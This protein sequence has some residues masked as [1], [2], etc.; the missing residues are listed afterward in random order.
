MAKIVLS[1]GSN[2]EPRINH[3][4]QAVKTISG[5]AIKGTMASSLFYETEP[6]GFISR[7]EFINMAISFNAD[8]SPS[9]LLEKIN[10]LEQSHGRI[11]NKGITEDRTIDID[12]LFYDDLILADDELTIPHPRLHLRNFVLTPLL[13][14]VPDMIHPILNKSVWELYDECKDTNEVRILE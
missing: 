10:H 12:I 8:L 6:N 11:R 2:I 13:D 3:L 7:N 1:L 14:I 5:W 9:D 4:Q